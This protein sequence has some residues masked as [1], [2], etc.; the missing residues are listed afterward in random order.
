[1]TSTDRKEENKYLNYLQMR[2][3]WSLMTMTALHEQLYRSVAKPNVLKEA[4]PTRLG[5]IRL[6]RW[7]KN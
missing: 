6:V 1:M 5:R 3:E 2:E 4:L 7:Y